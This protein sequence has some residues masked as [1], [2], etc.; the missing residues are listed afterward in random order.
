MRDKTFS[1]LLMSRPKLE[2][3]RF[4]LNNQ[5]GS[6]TINEVAENVEASYSTVNSFVKDLADFGALKIDEKGSAKVVSV[7]KHSPY[8]D[9]LSDLGSL[10][11]KPLIKTAEDYAEFLSPENYTKGLGKP[12]IENVSAIVLFGSVARGMPDINSDIDI[13]ILVEDQLEAIEEFA[14][15]KADE[16]GRKRD[17]QISPLVMSRKKFE[18]NLES[19]DPLAIKIKKNGKVLEYEKTWEEITE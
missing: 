16:I 15:D 1:D 7:N 13:L 8:I 14:Q 6:F 4:L 11:A 5:E 3:L 18:R 2:C 12:D 19:G 10:D 9:V 17:V